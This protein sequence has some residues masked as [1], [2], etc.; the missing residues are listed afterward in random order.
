MKG[1]L[2]DLAAGPDPSRL[3]VAGEAIGL[4]DAGASMVAGVAL[5]LVDVDLALLP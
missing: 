5:T 2:T 4:V 1:R 3:T